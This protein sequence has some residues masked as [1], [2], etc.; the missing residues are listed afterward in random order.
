AA[1]GENMLQAKSG[2]VHVVSVASAGEVPIVVP[3]GPGV[4]PMSQFANLGTITLTNNARIAAPPADGNVTPGGRIL[5]RGGKLMLDQGSA[6]FAS[7][8]GNIDA[9]PVAMDIQIRGNI[10]LD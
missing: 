5:M 2:E 3:P 10:T 6:V 4:L 9:P 8:G 7:T 1:N